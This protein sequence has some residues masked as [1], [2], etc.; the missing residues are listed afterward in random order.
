MSSVP[1]FVLK[2]FLLFMPK[3]VF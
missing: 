2:L 3:L 1:N